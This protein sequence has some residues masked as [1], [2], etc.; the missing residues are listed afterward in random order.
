M[1]SSTDSD[2]E[3]VARNTLEEFNNKHYDATAIYSVIRSFQEA[4]SDVDNEFQ[5]FVNKMSAMDDTWR[6]WGRFVFED[7]LPYV[8]LF[9]AIRGENWNLRTAAIKMMAANFTAF[10]HP[11]YQKLITNHILDMMHMPDELLEYF[12]SG[13]FAVSS[14]GHTFHSVGLDESHEMLINKH[15]KQAVVR[16]TKDYINRIARYIPLRIKHIEHLKRELFGERCEQGTSTTRIMFTA[17]PSV[18]KRETNIQAQLDK[19]E[20]GK[21]L[22]LEITHNRGVVNSFRDLVAND[23]QRH[24]L[25]NFHQIG[26]EIF[27]TRIKAYILKTPSVKVP[28]RRKKLQ[29]FGTKSKVTKQKVN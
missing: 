19:L 8:A 24:D 2:I 13:G 6:F 9:I 7:C 15:V 27:E 18:I 11:I 1:N 22:P 17:D 20:E 16:P 21:L 23:A 5:S 29:T 28:Q 12:R 3:Q 4:T 10:D 26:R 14:S 25:L